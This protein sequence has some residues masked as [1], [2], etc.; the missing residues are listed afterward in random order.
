LKWKSLH[1]TIKGKLDM[2]RD[3][4]QNHFKSMEVLMAVLTLLIGVV[5]MEID[6][7]VDT[8]EQAEEVIKDLKNSTT[9]VRLPGISHIRPAGTMDMSSKGVINVNPSQVQY[10]QILGV[11]E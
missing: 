11:D 3:W 9:L 8:R 1:L 4:Q 7:P 6:C 10:T 5:G 2:L